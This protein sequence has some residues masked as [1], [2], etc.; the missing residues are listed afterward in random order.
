[1]KVLITSI[2]IVLGALLTGCADDDRVDRVSH[3]QSQSEHVW[4]EQTDALQKADDVNKLMLETDQKRR[5]AL[6]E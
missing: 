2:T 5:E 3:D 1:M 6:G 4:K